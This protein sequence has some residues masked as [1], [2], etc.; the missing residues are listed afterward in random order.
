M[1]LLLNRDNVKQLLTMRE[2]IDI[3]EEA[4]RQQALGSVVMP[5]RTTMHLPDSHGAHLGMPAYIG[6]AV[7]ALALKVVTVFPDNPALHGLPTT[8]GILLLNDAKTGTPLA[9]IEA[10]FLTA[11]RTGAV[12]GVAAKYL[13]KKVAR[14]VGIFGGG[15]QAQTQ[16]MALSEVRDIES[17]VVFDRDMGKAKVFAE[18]MK[19]ILAIS[20]TIAEDA[21][22]AVEGVDIIVTASSAT[23]PLFDGAWLTPGQHISAIG[24]HTPATREIDSTTIVRSKVV[25][26]FIDACLSEAGDILI[27]IQEGVFRKEL[28]HASLGEIIA[29]KKP[30]RVNNE[31]ITFFKSVGLA[32]QDAATASY[33]YKKALAENIGVE[34]NFT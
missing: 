3:V 27:P 33:V 7:D 5:L 21:R 29:G 14:R 34:F 8:M 10:G 26:D 6:G 19:R 18:E 32:L 16:L 24:T 4:F 9:V 15:I 17:A 31:E 25:P 1:A 30:G 2:T 22:G 11:M 28:I 23:Q 20:M 13:A 12:T